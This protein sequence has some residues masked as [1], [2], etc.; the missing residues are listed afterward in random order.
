MKRDRDGSFTDLQEEM[1][2]N[3]SGGGESQQA[4]RPV[5]F[6]GAEP[7]RDLRKL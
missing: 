4:A 1:A 6:G 5:D 2:A 7:N 3:C